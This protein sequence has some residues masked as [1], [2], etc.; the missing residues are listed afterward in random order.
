MYNE[1]ESWLKMC[2]LAQQK[3]INNNDF[4]KKLKL[5]MIRK[6]QELENFSNKL[7][8]I[9]PQVL[10]N[11]QLMNWYEKFE[12]ITLKLRAY[13]WIPNLVDMGS[14]SIFDIVE[15]KIEKKIGKDDQIKEYISKLTTPVDITKQREHELNLYKIQ[16]LIQ[17]RH[18][19]NWQK[20]HL[21]DSLINQHLKKYGWLSYYYIGPSWSREEIIDILKN[22]FKLIKDPKDKIQEVNNYARTIRRKKDKIYKKIKSDAETRLLIE[23]ITTM[24]FL[25]AYRKEF[26]IYSNY[27]F[28]PFLKEIGHRLNLPLSNIRF[29]TKQE[30]KK[31]LLGPN[32]L[33]S[34]IRA[35]FIKRINIGC[36]SIASGSN[37]KIIDI[38]K[39]EKYFKLIKED[40]LIETDII[41]GN[42]AYP[43]SA[44][45]IVRV[46]NLR[47][48]IDKIKKGEILVSRAT[49]PDLI[50]AIQRA[51]AIVTDEGGITCH[52]AIVSRE[53]KKPCIIGT[54]VA[55]KVLKDGNL[56]E[57]D[58]GKGLVNI[59]KR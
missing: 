45:G 47:S 58:A 56:V 37:I 6:C 9:N 50:T 53:L 36:V 29:L 42:C 51:A 39:A 55:T 28:E 16:L 52:A 31:Y 24:I 25:K 17:R 57:V 7:L 38:N 43:G 27:C 44:R 1:Q 59:L 3:L 23:K 26:L 14:I 8:K 12:T 2:N 30:I 35:K 41:K 11:R 49:N 10:T 5:E 46:I 19:K 4:Y 20:D 15:R 33:K 54:R 21:I 18:I 32:Q 13:A 40:H 34:D 22:N 48:E